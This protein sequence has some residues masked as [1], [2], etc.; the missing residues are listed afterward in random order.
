MIQYLDSVNDITPEMLQG[1][2]V[3][4]RKPHTPEVHLQI[5]QKS[6]FVELALEPETN[7]V[8]GFCNAIS[9]GIQAAFISMLAVLP[10][11]QHQGVGRELM[12]RMLKRLEHI[13][14]V[15][16]TCNPE[17]QSFYKRFGMLPSVGIVVRN[18]K[19][20]YTLAKLLAGVT[21]ENRY[22]EI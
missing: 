18:Y 7:R 22:G 1:F 19:K 2:F 14:A 10:E 21:D 3:D 6:A 15:D 4:W 17:M 5:L 9:D 20:K 11:Y 12:R 13:S 8:V 16:L